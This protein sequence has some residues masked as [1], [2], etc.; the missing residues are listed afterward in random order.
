MKTVN[1]GKDIEL[2]IQNLIDTRLLIQAN[3]G[4]GKSYAIRK[5]LEATHGSVQQIVLDIEG[6][7]SSL[8]ERFDYVLAGKGKGVDIVA[9]PRSASYLARQVLELKID[10]IIDLYELKQHERIR[11]VKE[12]LDAM[13][14]APKDLWHS[15]LV[16]LDEAHIFCPEKGSAESMAAVTD[17]CTRGRKR[18]FCAVLATQRLS[19]L[20]KDAAAEC[21]NKLIGRTGLD[22]DLKRAIDE[23][24]LSSSEGRALKHLDPGE[25]FYF[26]PA[27]SREVVKG[28][29]GAT[30]T[31]H[32]RAGHR[33]IDHKPAPSA[34]VKAAL[35]K[36]GDIAKQADEEATTVRDLKAKVKELQKAKPEVS[37]QDVKKI[38]D[39]AIATAKRELE[40][41]MIAKVKSLK[42][43]ILETIS[44]FGKP[45]L[46]TPTANILFGSGIVKV[47]FDRPR[48]PAPQKERMGAAGGLGQ[49]E[50]KILGFLASQS[51]RRFTKVQIGAMTGYR[52]TSGGFKNSISKLTQ[53]SLIE[54][55]G[56]SIK[57]SSV[58][59]EWV[60][61]N[62]SDTPHALRDW[63]SKLGQCER[64]IYELLLSEPH[65]NQWPKEMI[66][67][68]TGYRASSGG[69]KNAIS[70]LNTLGL[71]TKEQSGFVK[72]N[73]DVIAA[74][75]E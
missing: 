71:I 17:L 7:F 56:D 18:G 25:F 1:L 4:G 65:D 22:I 14:N 48:M 53:L 64:T 40:I 30:K 35:A 68:K 6:D 55:T 29:I 74:A 38:A 67:E 32:P 57:I 8:R 47:E 62:G 46:D 12:F 50:R 37:K 69:F 15:A 31:S 26:G 51:D 44:E 60:E 42:E 21:N 3:S 24:G 23:L 70:R 49:C 9:D 54:R 43:S 16:V 75:G 19:K 36:M 5:L 39:R 45:E 34:T 63:I 58:G 52:H 33:N 10:I 59:I 66:A 20:N 28:K 27:L 41:Q 72:L 73:S 61:V 11:F 13:T 2:G